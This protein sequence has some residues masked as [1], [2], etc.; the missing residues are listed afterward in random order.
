MGIDVQ[1]LDFLMR[2]KPYIH[3]NLL[4][5]GRQGVHLMEPMGNAGLTEKIFRR[6][7]DQTPIYPLLKV[8]HAEELF[9]YLGATNVESM[10]ISSYEGCT[11]VHDLNNPVPEYLHDQ[12]DTIVDGGTIEHIFDVKTMF[13]NIKTMLKVNGT[14]ISITT[15]NNFVNHGFY[16]FSPELFFTVFS[17]EAG[18]DIISVELMDVNDQV[19]PHVIQNHSGTRTPIRPHSL[20]ET[21]IM[22]AAIKRDVVKLKNNYQQSDYLRIWG[23]NYDH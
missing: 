7:D 5:L 12:F 17:R 14:F 8:G 20:D 21:Y 3:G 9:E 22:T 1:G 4:Q 19:V 10:D 23:G 11:I 18:Y 15:A 6:Y 16:Q 2:M 13:E